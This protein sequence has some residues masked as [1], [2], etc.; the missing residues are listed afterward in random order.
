M[1]IGEAVK[2]GAKDADAMISAFH[3]AMNMPGKI[4]KNKVPAGIPQIE[5]YALSLS[6]YGKFME[7]NRHV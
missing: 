4:Q 6:E 3:F 1:G 5:E 2:M 7:V